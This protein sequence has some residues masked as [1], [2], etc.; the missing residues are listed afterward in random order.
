MLLVQLA[1]SSS[2]KLILMWDLARH[3]TLAQTNICTKLPV[4]ELSLGILQLLQIYGKR[5]RISKKMQ[6]AV[7]KHHHHR[8]LRAKSL[9]E[10]QASE[11]KKP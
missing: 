11:S 7:S 6:A 10:Q 1:L 5:P 3:I 2:G 9:S 8:S 4:R